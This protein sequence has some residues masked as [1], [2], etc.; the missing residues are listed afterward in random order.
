MHKLYEHP[1][2]QFLCSTLVVT[3]RTFR[4]SRPEVFLGKAV[5]KICSK[6]TGEDPCQSVIYWNYTSAWVFSYK[7]TAYFQNTFS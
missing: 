4:S 7:F 1:Y 6:F 3:Q 5:L 2:L